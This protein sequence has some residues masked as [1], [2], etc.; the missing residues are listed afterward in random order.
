MVPSADMAPSSGGTST[1]LLR[2]G[3]RLVTG[4]IVPLAFAT[5]LLWLVAY[6]GL[7]G[8]WARAWLRDVTA[9]GGVVVG[10]HRFGPW[11][12]E[13]RLAEAGLGADGV[14]LVRGSV[15]AEVALFP[16]ALSG[17]DLRADEIVVRSGPKAKERSAA[18]EEARPILSWRELDAGLRDVP[19]RVT[20]RVGTLVVETPQLAAWLE[21]VQV[22]ASGAVSTRLTASRCELRDLV[23]PAAWGGGGCRVEVHR[24]APEGPFVLTVELQGGLGSRLLV[25]VTLAP[26]GPTVEDAELSASVDV[27]LASG[28]VSLWSG[29]RGGGAVS[30]RGLRVEGWRP[31][32]GLGAVG[33]SFDALAVEHIDA[34]GARL[35]GLEGGRGHLVV[36]PDGLL[37]RVEVELVSLGLTSLSVGDLVV[38]RLDVGRL[39]FVLDRRLDGA[40]EGL[41][42]GAVATPFFE[43]ASVESDLV[44]AVGL[45]GGSLKGRLLTAHG[46]VDAALS[47]K[48][49]P[50]GGR[51]SVLL[52]VSSPELGGP[53]LDALAGDAPELGVERA[54]RVRDAEIALEL[55]DG[56]LVGTRDTLGVERDGRFWRFDGYDWSVE[57]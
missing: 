9:P 26:A 18:A 22:N 31:G 7:N 30:L 11:P 15:V 46:D 48:R 12:T 57:P 25:D 4:V 54:A 13:L 43:L 50:L 2:I 8:S 40:F 23:G 33:L 45:A 51:T 1:H 10:V 56:A 16:V 34:D 20:G 5:T 6:F 28:L 27:A 19:G 49:S 39:A 37:T 29:G 35:A 53:L 44:L 55:D 3:R 38:G 41:R 47:V 14:V 52:K 36:V 32:P 21:D 24:P 42:V 17:V